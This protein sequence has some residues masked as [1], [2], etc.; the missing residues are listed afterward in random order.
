[1]LCAL[2]SMY[3]RGGWQHAHTAQRNAA[4]GSR[5]TPARWAAPIGANSAASVG[6][7]WPHAS[8]GASRFGEKDPDYAAAAGRAAPDL[9]TFKTA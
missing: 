4:L 7:E 6:W 5:G 8:D 2:R 1:M 9:T 3:T